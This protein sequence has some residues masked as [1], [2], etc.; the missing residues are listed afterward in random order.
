MKETVNFQKFKCDNCGRKSGLMKQLSR[1]DERIFPY[2]KGWIYIHSFTAKS[3]LDD[4]IR[5]F[6]A[7]DRHFCCLDC[8]IHFI[9]CKI[10]PEEEKK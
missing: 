6:M 2:D 5:R 10:K 9:K 4:N 3:M 7:Q 1:A 8:L